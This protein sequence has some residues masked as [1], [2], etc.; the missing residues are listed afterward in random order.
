MNVDME[1]R[2]WKIW[3]VDRRKLFATHWKYLGAGAGKTEQQCPERVFSS[4]DAVSQYSLG[5]EP[6]VGLGA[7]LLIFLGVGVFAAG[8]AQAFQ[9]VRHFILNIDN[10]VKM[11]DKWAKT[12]KASIRKFQ[13][14][15]S[16]P[17]I[18]CSW[19]PFLFAILIYIY[20]HDEHW[21]VK[22]SMQFLFRIWSQCDIMIQCDPWLR[23]K[24][25]QNCVSVSRYCHKQRLLTQFVSHNVIMS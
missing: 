13:S 25:P 7:A 10:W 9:M 6:T 19:P 23:I 1:W 4:R 17:C 2:H 21:N 12:L 11:L 20:I 14:T 16:V 5:V 8:I 15:I 22:V 3:Y 24:T 18:F